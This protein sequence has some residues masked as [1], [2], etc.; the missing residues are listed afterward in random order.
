MNA[1]ANRIIYMNN[2][3]II[4]KCNT[5]L[6]MHNI[7]VEDTIRQIYAYENS[8][9]PIMIIRSAYYGEYNANLTIRKHSSIIHRSMNIE[10]RQILIRSAWKWRR[11][12]FGLSTP[13]VMLVLYHD[14]VPTSAASISQ[15]YSVY[16]KLLL[17]QQS[18]NLYNKC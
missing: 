7:P 8:L 18:V 5:M 2:I 12:I 6:I 4:S 16:F 15:N 1:Q 13:R 11:Y 17:I 3:I 9:Y 10:Q 14:G